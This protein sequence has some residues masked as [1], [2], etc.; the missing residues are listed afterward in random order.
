MWDSLAFC[1]ELGPGRWGGD[2]RAIADRGK[3]EVTGFLSSFINKHLFMTAVS[4]LQ[5]T[6]L[7][8]GKVSRASLIC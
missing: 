5:Q 6:L 3:S 2:K 8:S 1:G 7:L 4:E